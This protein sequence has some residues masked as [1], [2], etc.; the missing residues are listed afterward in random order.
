M[1]AQGYSK[2]WTWLGISNLLICFGTWALTQGVILLPFGGQLDSRRVPSALF[3]IPASSALTLISLLISKSY[4]NKYIKKHN[5]IPQR[6]P[7]AFSIDMD[8]EL[9]EKITKYYQYFF[10]FVFLAFPLIAQIHFFSVIFHENITIHGSINSNP[11]NFFTISYPSSDYRLGENGPTFF[12]F[13]EPILLLSFWL[14]N[15][16]FFATYIFSLFKD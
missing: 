2:V 10:L 6:I 4:L 11:I 1:T 8:W 3:A 12:P 13:F 9:Q 14:L 5:Y 15:F 7:T 16:L